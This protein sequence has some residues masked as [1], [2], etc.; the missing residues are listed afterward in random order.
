M[1]LLDRIFLQ[2]MQRLQHN[3][4]SVH[5][6]IMLN[7]AVKT[8]NHQGRT[9]C[10]HLWETCPWEDQHFEQLEQDAFLKIV[11]AVKSNLTK[12]KSSYSTK[13]P[14]INSLGIM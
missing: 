9:I 2:E 3:S 12:R 4:E 14:L 5:K 6:I 11:P 8:N 10:A 1:T 13:T 7:L